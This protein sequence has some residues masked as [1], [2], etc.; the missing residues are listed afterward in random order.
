M[1]QTL[2]EDQ[3]HLVALV[4][5]GDLVAQPR[6]IDSLIAERS[7]DLGIVELGADSLAEMIDARLI[8]RGDDS[9]GL[10]GLCDHFVEQSELFGRSDFVF[11]HEKALP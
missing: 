7:P 1:T 9:G 3:L 2:A 4:A 11:G 8:V 6:L 10:A 5:L